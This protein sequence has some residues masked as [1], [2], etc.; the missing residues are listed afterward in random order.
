MLWV[1]GRILD[2]GYPRDSL[3]WYRWLAGSLCEMWHSHVPRKWSRCL[4]LL[5]LSVSRRRTI[6]SGRRGRTC[7]STVVQGV[8]ARPLSSAIGHQFDAFSPWWIWIYSGKNGITW[9]QLKHNIASPHILHETQLVS[10]IVY[11]SSFSSLTAA[12][13]LTSMW[14]AWNM[15][16]LEMKRLL[17]RLSLKA[18]TLPTLRTPFASTLPT[19]TPPSSKRDR[20]QPQHQTPKFNLLRT[21]RKTMHVLLQMMQS[22]EYTKT[23]ALAGTCTMD[24]WQLNA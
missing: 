21:P 17:Q 4:R 14:K 13:P 6:D 16:H 10:F 9:F 5:R 22:R 23:V 1:G 15:E 20:G 3:C 19:S 18:T 2:F 8:C 12:V 11:R 24:F 7:T